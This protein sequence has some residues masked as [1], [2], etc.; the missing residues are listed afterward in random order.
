[1]KSEK[2]SSNINCVF[3]L[4]EVILQLI[5]FDQLIIIIALENKQNWPMCVSMWSYLS[6]AE[7][8]TQD[9]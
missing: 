5:W 7:A 9:S 8:R 4:F 1:M 2:L 6:V 3:L